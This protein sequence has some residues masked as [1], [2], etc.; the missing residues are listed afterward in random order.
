[1]KIDESV[2]FLGPVREIPDLLQIVDLGILISPFQRGEGMS[3]AIL[4]YM[5]AGL[6]VV[7][8]DITSIRETVGE[9]NFKY[10][11]PLKDAEKLSEMILTFANNKEFRQDVGRKIANGQKSHFPLS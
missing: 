3:N 4:E 1:L 5:A 7:S 8:T 10:L 11:M 2:I 6:P 9:E